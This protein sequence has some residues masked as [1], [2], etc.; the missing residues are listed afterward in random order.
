MKRRSGLLVIAPMLIASAALGQGS[1]AHQA[2]SPDLSQLTGVWRG[3]ME[4]LPA[5]DLV[6]SDESGTLTGAVLFYFHLRKTVNDPWSST[7]GLPEPLFNLKLD[8][9]MLTFQVSHRRA[10]PPRTL[11]DPPVQF[12]LRLTGPNKAELVNESESRSPGPGLNLVRS[13]Y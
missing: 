13:E 5:V 12:R 6:I 1:L 7:P 8:G 2:P 11:T 10:H 3:Q 9:K 4:G